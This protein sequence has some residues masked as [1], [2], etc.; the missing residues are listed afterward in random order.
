VAQP[1]AREEKPLPVA[2]AALGF[3]RRFEPEEHARVT[4][5]LVPSKVDDKWSIRFAEGWLLLRRRWTGICI[6]AVRLEAEG[7]GSVVREAWVN[8]DPAEYT[9]TDDA[10]DARMLGYLVDHLLLGRDVPFPY[11]P[12]I[13]GTS[14]S[15]L[16]KNVVVGVAPGKGSKG[17]KG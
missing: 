12:S 2:R 4:G 17:G 10:Y 3:E 6:Y 7:D 5:G 8:R 15:D 13:E 9:V 16:F 14:K 11:P 1:P